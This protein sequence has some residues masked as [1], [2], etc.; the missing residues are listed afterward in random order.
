MFVVGTS[1]DRRF[2]DEL[3]SQ[4]FAGVASRVQL[5]HPM[6]ASAGKRA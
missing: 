2:T 3:V 6:S 4:V 5:S 1:L